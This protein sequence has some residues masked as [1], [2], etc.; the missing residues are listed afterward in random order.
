[1]KTALLLSGVTENPLENEGYFAG[2]QPWTIE[3]AGEPE[4]GLAASGY[5]GTNLLLGI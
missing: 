3:S 2:W 5:S 1:M 4:T